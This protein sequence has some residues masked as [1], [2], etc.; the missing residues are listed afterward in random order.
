MGAWAFA[1][2]RLSER[3]ADTHQMHRVSRFESGSP[4]TGSHAIHVQE[5]EP[6]AILD[7]ALG[8]LD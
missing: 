3:F 8:T 7:L 6:S 1:Q 5:Q 4:A 2:D